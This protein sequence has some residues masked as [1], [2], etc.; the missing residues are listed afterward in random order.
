MKTKLDRP[1]ASLAALTGTK[2]TAPYAR[3]YV[4]KVLKQD[5][6]SLKLDVQPEDPTLPPMS[7]IPLWTGSAGLRFRLKDPKKF[8]IKC[9]VGFAD[10]APDKPFAILGE[11]G[12]TRAPRDAIEQVV[13]EGLSVQLGAEGLTPVQDGVVTG[14]GKDPYTSLPYWMLGSSSAVV[15]AKK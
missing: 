2:P 1:K 4:A 13:I 14:Q 10:G 7:G 6:G 9:L 5:S 3:L 11:A 8:A 15:S 12:I